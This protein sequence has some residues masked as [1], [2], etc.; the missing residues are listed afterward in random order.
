MEGMLKDN[1]VK[2]VSGLEEH[3]LRG[4]LNTVPA[5]CMLV[6]IDNAV[7][8]VSLICDVVSVNACTT[9]ANCL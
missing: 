3:K 1:L 7:N 9:T 4:R 6:Q 5:C 8:Q 2:G